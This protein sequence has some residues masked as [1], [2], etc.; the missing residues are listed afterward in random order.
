[1]KLKHDTEKRSVRSKTC[2]S[3]EEP[4]WVNRMIVSLRRGKK[5]IN[6]VGVQAYFDYRKQPKR[7]DDR[8][9]W[10]ESTDILDGVSHERWLVETTPSNGDWKGL[11]HYFDGKYRSSRRRRK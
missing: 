5:L 4:V 1:M 7:I 3:K 11:E 6:A 10:Y 9:S 2:E 8:N